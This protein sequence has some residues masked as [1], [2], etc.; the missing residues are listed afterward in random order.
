MERLVRGHLCGSTELS[1]SRA[2]GYQVIALP[3]TRLNP[4]G[5]TS[6]V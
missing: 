3:E 2:D 1:N 4:S 6:R 5:Q